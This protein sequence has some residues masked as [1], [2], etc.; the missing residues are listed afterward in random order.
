MYRID[1]MEYVLLLPER[2]G[3]PQVKMVEV[4]MV[5]LEA[6]A[7]CVQLLVVPMMAEVMTSPEQS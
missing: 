6:T 5:V 1:S 4:A 7:L 2:E 3:V